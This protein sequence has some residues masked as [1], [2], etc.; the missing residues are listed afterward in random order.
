MIKKE[1]SEGRYVRE[2]ML[3]WEIGAASEKA[4]RTGLEVGRC[5]PWHL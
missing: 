1:F 4:P 2:E 3:G 5:L